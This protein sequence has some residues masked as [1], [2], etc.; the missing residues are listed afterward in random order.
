MADYF[1]EH[2]LGDT[3]KPVDMVEMNREVEQSGNKR[4]AL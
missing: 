3:T 4:K 1:S 2:L